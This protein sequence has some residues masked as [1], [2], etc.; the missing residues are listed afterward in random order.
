MS[1]RIKYTSEWLMS[2][3]NEGVDPDLDATLLALLTK[4]WKIKLQ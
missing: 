1:R 4:T 2:T 3:L